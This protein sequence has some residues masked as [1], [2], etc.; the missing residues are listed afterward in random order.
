[1]THFIALSHK[2]KSA[3]FNFLS[4]SNRASQYECFAFSSQPARK[5][6]INNM[7]IKKI[8]N[9][10]L[11]FVLFM[12]SKL[13]KHF[14]ISL[15]LSQSHSSEIWILLWL[16]HRYA[17]FYCAQLTI[18]TS[19]SLVMCKQGRTQHQVYLPGSLFVKFRMNI[20]SKL[21]YKTNKT[22]IQC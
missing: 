6:V 20:L 16:L 21:G 18:R 14:C 9:E 1:M 15:L 12:H 11:R 19:A 7:T 3:D 17:A 13:N 4:N 10:L 22:T 8:K 5:N 2:K